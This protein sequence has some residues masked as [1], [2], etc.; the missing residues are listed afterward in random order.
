MLNSN[1]MTAVLEF[2]QKRNWEQF[3]KP[4]ELAAALTVEASELLEV[5]QWKSHDEAI[6]AKVAVDARCWKREVG[7]AEDTRLE[8][9]ARPARLL[10]AGGRRVGTITG[11]A[12]GIEVAARPRGTRVHC[13]GIARLKHA[14][15]R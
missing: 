5:F 1:V 6:A 3:H 4:K 2:R 7:D 13:Y 12:V 8:A 14:G 10:N 15:T 11:D 9:G